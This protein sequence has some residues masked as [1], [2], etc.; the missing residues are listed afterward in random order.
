MATKDAPLATP[1]VVMCVMVNDI[2]T[3]VI[4]V[5][6]SPGER[7]TVDLLKKKLR[8]TD[9]AVRTQPEDVPSQCCTKGNM[10]AH[11]DSRL[12]EVDV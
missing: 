12:E 11:Q 3:P 2:H 7:I 4:A 6:T 10:Y 9:D 8:L 5:K 1:H